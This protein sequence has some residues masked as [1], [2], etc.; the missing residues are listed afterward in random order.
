MKIKNFFHIHALVIFGVL[1]LD[2]LTK[3]FINENCFFS[4]CIKKAINDG[5]SFGIFGGMGI[6]PFLIIFSSFLLVLMIYLYNKVNNKL[7]LAF[8]FLIAGTLSNLIDRMFY[9]GV[10]D[11]LSIFHSSAFNI[12][13]LSNLIGVIILGCNIFST[14]KS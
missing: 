2:R 7:K 8:S 3:Q 11:W 14:T 9:G 1:L 4:I 5:A 6:T 13:D 12:A 10:I